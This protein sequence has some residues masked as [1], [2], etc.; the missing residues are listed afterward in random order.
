MNGEETAES[1]HPAT[2]GAAEE[3]ETVINSCYYDK[4]KSFFDNLSDS[5][6]LPSY[7]HN[8]MSF[9]SSSSSCARSLKYF[10]PLLK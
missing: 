7:S 9:F 6:Y 4:S 10:S 8:K 5:R 3:E 1:D 2:E